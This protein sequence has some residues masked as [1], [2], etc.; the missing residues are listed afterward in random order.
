MQQ[1]SHVLTPVLAFFVFTVINICNTR[2]AFCGL[3][4]G[5]SLNEPRPLPQTTAIGP[6]FSIN[7]LFSHH[8][9]SDYDLLW[10]AYT[11]FHY[12]WAPFRAPLYL[13]RA[14]LL[15]HHTPFPPVVGFG[16][17]CAGCD[18]RIHI[19]VYVSCIIVWLVSV[20]QIHHC[21]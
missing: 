12:K 7:P 1:W 6:Q 5:A 14:N 9:M 19:R 11:T 2:N 20:L 10:P 16:V 3:G 18:I 17:V 8:W 13:D 4:Y 21:L 15:Y